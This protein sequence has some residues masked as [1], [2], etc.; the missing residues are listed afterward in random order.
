M[1]NFLQSKKIYMLMILPIIVLAI[2]FFK[3]YQGATVQTMLW[4]LNLPEQR[5]IIV[6]SALLLLATV[7]LFFVIN[8]QTKIIGQRTTLPSTIFVMLTAGFYF[9]D[10]PVGLLGATALTLL[11]VMMQFRSYDETVGNSANFDVGFLFLGAIL[12]M[13]KFIF[14]LPYG[15]LTILLFSKQSGKGVVAYFI[16]ILTA[17]FFAESISF[18]QEGELL[19]TSYVLTT[20]RSGELFNF[21]VTNELLFY[22]IT[23]LLLL[24]IALF[25]MWTQPSSLTIAQRKAV[26][27]IQWLLLF[28]VCSLFMIPNSFSSGIL[29]VAAIPSAFL[30]A[31][32]LIFSKNKIVRNSYFFFVFLIALSAFLID[33]YSEI[34]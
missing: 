31:M 13:P 29:F 12:L 8:E 23:S 17:A 1:G 5:Y 24:I 18:L 33:I 25:K 6:F 21:V 4:G 27:S 15:F 26:N 28:I 9:T 7:F 32:F 34:L 10:A 3:L 19:M 30:M 2:S 14:L 20:I 11:A 16:G 22:C